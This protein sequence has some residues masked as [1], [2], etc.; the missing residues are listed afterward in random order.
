MGLEI[1]LLD[2][3]AAVIVDIDEPPA[4]VGDDGGDGGVAGFLRSERG[5]PWGGY[6][7]LF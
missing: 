1:V 5:V 2:H 7:K 6:F 3:L 4:A